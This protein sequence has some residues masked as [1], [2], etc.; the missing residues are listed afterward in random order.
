VQPIQEKTLLQE[1][2]P[3]REGGASREECGV[4]KGKS[5]EMERDIVQGTQEVSGEGTNG[6]SLKKK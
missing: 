1:S 2:K 3:R 6:W 5:R 4:A